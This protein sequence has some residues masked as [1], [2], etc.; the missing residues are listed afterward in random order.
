MHVLPTRFSEL[1][2]LLP[3]EDEDEESIEAAAISH[4]YPLHSAEHLDT[5]NETEFQ[6]VQVI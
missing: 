3:L 5:H 2:D 1:C 6:S 4:L